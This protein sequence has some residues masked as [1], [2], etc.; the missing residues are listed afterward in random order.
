MFDAKKSFCPHSDSFFL[1]Y[2]RWNSH[3]QEM[4][5][6]AETKIFSSEIRLSKVGRINPNFLFLEIKAPFERF[7]V[8]LGRCVGDNDEVWTFAMNTES[9]KVPIVLL[10]GFGA[11]SAFWAM[12]LEN[13]AIEHPVYAF[14]TLGFARSSRPVFSNDPEEIEQQFVDSIE[15][16]REVLGLERMVLLGHSFGGFLAGSYALKYPD[17]LEHLIMVDPWGVD[18]APEMQDFPLWKLSVAYTVRLMVGPFS[19][20]RALGPFGEWLIKNVR[21]DLLQKYESI[22]DPSIFSQ[23]I[24]HCNNN[25]NPTG[26]AAFHRMTVVGPW[27]QNPV[28]ER[29]KHGLKDDLPVTFLYGAN[30]W[31]NNIYGT[32]IKES[33]PK[34]Y[35]NVKIVDGAGHH[36]YTDNAP[37]FN[38]CVMDACG[39][40][41][42]ERN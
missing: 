33:R 34:S 7:H 41:K 17:R 22:V 15:R 30:T 32:I 36:I 28:G 1:T 6:D 21:P 5:E 2:L 38:K 35:T 12:N 40:L 20:I 42:T 10:H 37:E 39:I 23:Y 16:W 18:G 25:S 4:L 8:K 13:L 29:L 26:E 19:M 27:P 3:S 9:D 24:Y 11:G 14:D 31:M